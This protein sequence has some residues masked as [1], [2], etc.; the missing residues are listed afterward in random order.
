MVRRM[1][2]N[3]NKVDTTLQLV[4]A[5]VA[6]EEHQAQQM[7]HQVKAVEVDSVKVEHEEATGKREG[8]QGSS[9]LVKGRNRNLIVTEK[10]EVKAH[11]EAEKEAQEE[12][13][14]VEEAIQEVVVILEAEGALG[15]DHT[16]VEEETIST[17]VGALDLEEVAEVALKDD[18]IH[19][20]A[21]RRLLPKVLI[22]EKP[23]KKEAA[24]REASDQKHIKGDS[25]NNIE[26][27]H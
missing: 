27:Y 15:D 11:S 14:A 12:A 10:M 8:S 6:E 24:K 7:E 23:I 21:E 16:A 19:N 20:S 5:E 18:R 3:S 22:K 26:L 4:V 1:S 2:L 25:I 13:E 9:R 17:V